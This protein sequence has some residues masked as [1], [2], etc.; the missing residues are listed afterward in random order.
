VI[1]LDENIFESGRA[2]LRKWRMNVRQIGYDVGHKGMSDD[3]IIPL[4]RRLQRP[5]FFT[6]DADFFA[7]GLC[8]D[9]FSLAFLDLKSFDAADYIR[10]FLKHPEFRTWARR[11]GCVTRIA[12]SG[13]SVWRLH[14][15]RVAR[16][17]WSG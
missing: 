15:Q 3:E 4:L 9:R 8:S 10:R 17:Q 16:Y 14:A 6:R 13:I 2:H 5:T 7:R 11:K 1:V 12:R